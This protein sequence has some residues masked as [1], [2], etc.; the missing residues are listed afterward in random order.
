MRMPFGGYKNF[1]DCVSKNRDKSDPQAYCGSIKAKTEGKAMEQDENSFFKLMNIDVM[2]SK[3]EAG[4]TV[5]RGVLSSTGVDYDNERLTRKALEK[6]ALQLPGKTV[7]FN[8]K[9]DGLGV[10]AFKSARVE[11]LDNGIS[12]LVVEVIPSKAPGVQD[13]VIQVNEGTL[14]CMSI[15]GKKLSK[16]RAVMDKLLNKEVIELDDIL[17]LEGSVVGIGANPDASLFGVA[18]SMFMKSQEKSLGDA[19]MTE[20]PKVEVEKDA[21]LTGSGAQA[22]TPNFPALVP[23]GEGIEGAKKLLMEA[24]RMLGGGK[25]ASYGTPSP[26]LQTHNSLKSASEEDKMQKILDKLESMSP[27]KQGLVAK[28]AKFEA[29]PEIA[30]KTNQLVNASAIEAF[31]KT[32]K[33]N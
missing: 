14:K 25:D 2:K 26:D 30:P 22:S 1:D 5:W 19:T 17:A 9:H 32:I 6:A 20:E 11:D 8:H 33:V 27:G 12:N 29:T 15:G 3:G 13:I 31:K 10:G 24:L 18:K 28:E 7:F 21:R 16:G 23:G 4:E